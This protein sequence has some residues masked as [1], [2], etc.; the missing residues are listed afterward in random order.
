VRIE[1]IFVA[2]RRDISSKD[3][4]NAARRNNNVTAVAKLPKRRGN[5]CTVFA[6]P[7][8]RSWL[9]LA[10]ACR[11]VGYFEPAQLSG[12]PAMTIKIAAY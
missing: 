2:W 6:P 10:E 9:Y 1:A 8:S 5:C 4:Q 3:C 7:R 11:L 12:S